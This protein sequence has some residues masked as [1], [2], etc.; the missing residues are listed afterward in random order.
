MLEVEKMILDAK[1]MKE[2][3][4]DSATKCAS[5]GNELL[6]QAQQYR[7]T[8]SAIEDMIASW[9]RQQKQKGADK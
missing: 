4:R 8:A 6:R 7:E 3:Y 5:S 1:K 9:E 2:F